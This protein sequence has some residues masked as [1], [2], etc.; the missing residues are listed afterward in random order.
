M[1]AC[2]DCQLCCKLLP[3]RSI[4]KLANVRCDHQ[5]HKKG[6]AVYPQLGFISP[7]CRLWSCRWLVED[8][9]A[10]QSRP[11]RS[12]IVIDLVPDMITAKDDNTEVRIK[13]IQIWCD[14]GFPD[15]H[16]ADAIR[17]YMFRRA[18]KGI[19][20]L[21][22]FDSYRCLLVVPPPMNSAGEWFERAHVIPQLPESPR[23]DSSKS[24]PDAPSY[25]YA[26]R[27]SAG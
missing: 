23:I 12:H 16:R 6:C 4:S 19:A 10:D 25:R 22:R 21:V 20:S 3:V 8:D 27:L 11:D 2:G 15:A 9:T 14:P 13:V 5:R 24:A 18:T 1:R 7:E 17:R 26:G